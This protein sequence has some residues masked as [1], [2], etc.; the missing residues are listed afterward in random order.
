MAMQEATRVKYS[1][2]AAF[3]VGNGDNGAKAARDARFAP[4]SAKQTAKRLLTTDYVK[5]EISK[6][7]AKLAKKAAYTIEQAELE[8]E[9]ARLL[10]IQKEQGG[11][12][13][14][15]VTGKARLYGMDKDSG[16]G[17]EQTVIIIGPKT[18]VKAIESRPGA[19][20]K[21]IEGETTNG[22]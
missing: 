9:Q 6:L 12:A 1:L 15:A 11:A 22:V 4:N 21:Q 3:Y 8:Y 2:F 7:R 20:D 18:P 19:S 17:R 13:V 14:A 16:G 10:S 5:A